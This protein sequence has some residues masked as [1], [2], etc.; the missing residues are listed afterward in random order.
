M[1]NHQY[2]EVCLCPHALSWHETGSVRTRLAWLIGSLTVCWPSREPFAIA[3]KANE[4]I[5]L[6]HLI[7]AAFGFLLPITQAYVKKL[8]GTSD[9]ATVH[10]NK[11]LKSPHHS[12]L[13]H[14][15]CLIV[16]WLKSRSRNVSDTV[17]E[18]WKKRCRPKRLQT[19]NSI[20]HFGVTVALC[21]VFLQR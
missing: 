4:A 18:K 21:S 6:H 19:K 20:R 15:I 11:I 5:K 17:P 10:E 12:C 9:H 1:I 13:H 14:P 7:L 2:L 16:D 8:L 3:K